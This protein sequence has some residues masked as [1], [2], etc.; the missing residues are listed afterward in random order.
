LTFAYFYVVRA[1]Q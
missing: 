1:R